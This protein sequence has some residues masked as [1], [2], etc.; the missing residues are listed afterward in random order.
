MAG[1]VLPMENRQ[2]RLFEKYDSRPRGEL[3]RKR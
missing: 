3:A 2:T 1:R